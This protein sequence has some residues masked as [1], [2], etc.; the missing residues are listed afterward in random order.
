MKEEKIARVGIKAIKLALMEFKR[1]SYQKKADP[2]VIEAL[3]AA[4]LYLESKGWEK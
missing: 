2:R 3:E 1:I 4:L